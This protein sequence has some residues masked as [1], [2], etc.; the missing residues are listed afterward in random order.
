MGCDECPN[1]GKTNL[2]HCIFDD[3]IAVF[4]IEGTLIRG[5]LIPSVGHEYT[6]FC[7]IGRLRKASHSPAIFHFR[8]RLRS[9]K[10]IFVLRLVC[11]C[12]VW[13]CSCW[14]HEDGA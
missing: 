13:G 10:V 1:G 5:K 3:K 7:Q 2:V 4:V 12:E 11:I 8:S 9:L 14:F 6:L